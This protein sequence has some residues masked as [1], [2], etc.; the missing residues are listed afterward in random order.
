MVWDLIKK[1][2]MSVE[3]II[4]WIIAILVVILVLFFLYKYGAFKHL[5]L[6]PNYANNTPEFSLGILR[7]GK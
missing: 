4:P 1:A 7:G 5:D 6:I 3:K 2:Q